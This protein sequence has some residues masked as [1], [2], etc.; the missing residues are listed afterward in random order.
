MNLLLMV[1]KM[2]NIKDISYN[3]WYI[4]I[5]KI[6]ADSNRIVNN[7]FWA[8]SPAEDT[9][10]EDTKISEYSWEKEKSISSHTKEIKD[11][12]KNKEATYCIY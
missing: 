1:E 9:K 12:A 7:S 10:N 4:N 6:I 3:R 5:K 8:P 2:D 11:K